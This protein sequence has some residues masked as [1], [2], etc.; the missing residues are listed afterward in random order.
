MFRKCPNCG[1]GATI[2]AETQEDA[3]RLAKSGV[4]SVWCMRC[5]F[6]GLMSQGDQAE[7]AKDGFV[8]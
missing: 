8:R 1:H 2:E 3:V 6:H 5:E 7:I 4:L